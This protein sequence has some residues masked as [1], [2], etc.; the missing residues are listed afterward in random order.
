MSSVLTVKGKERKDSNELM[1]KLGG[2]KKFV[3]LVQ[4]VEHSC[5]YLF[6][7]ST[8]SGTTGHFLQCIQLKTALKATFSPTPSYWQESFSPASV[9]LETHHSVLSVTR[10]GTGQMS[11]SLNINVSP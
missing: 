2:N 1:L 6:T 7:F 4:T 5:Y 8:R 11:N 10:T 3:I 9:I